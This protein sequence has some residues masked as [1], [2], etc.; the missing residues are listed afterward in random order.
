MEK[1][2]L[3]TYEG[4]IRIAKAEEKDWGEMREE[5]LMVWRLGSMWGI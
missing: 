5:D 1:A 2:L 3:I 4:A